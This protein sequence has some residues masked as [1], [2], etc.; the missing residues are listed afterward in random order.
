MHSFDFT[1]TRA[2]CNRLNTLH[3]CRRFHDKVEPLNLCDVVAERLPRHHVVVPK[4]SKNQAKV[5]RLVKR[6]DCGGSFSWPVG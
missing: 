3:H 5:G 1:A 6:G 4:E 2:E